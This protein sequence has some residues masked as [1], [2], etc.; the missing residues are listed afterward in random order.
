MGLDENS[1]AQSAAHEENRMSYQINAIYQDSLGQRF[2]GQVIKGPDG[3]WSLST[4]RAIDYYIEAGDVEGGYVEFVGFDLPD[5]HARVD[6]G[7][8]L[9]GSFLPWPVKPE[10]S[11]SRLPH[12]NSF[13]QLQRIAANR[14]AE[15]H[16]RRERERRRI[17]ENSNQRDPH[18]VRQARNINNLIAGQRRPKRTG[19]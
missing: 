10:I 18:A 1:E 13:Q 2:S 15:S 5:S 6:G 12:E 3:T 8:M 17:L 19:E 11:D 14:D 7:V 16:R 4:G 9:D